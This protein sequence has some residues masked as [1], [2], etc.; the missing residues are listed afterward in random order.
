M[1]EGRGSATW[2]DV[3]GG[4][5]GSIVGEGFACADKAES[6]FGIVGG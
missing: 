6:S 2:G 3:E 4:G 1:R 5:E